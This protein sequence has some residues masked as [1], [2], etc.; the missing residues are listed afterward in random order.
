MTKTKKVKKSQYTYVKVKKPKWWATPLIFLMMI[1]VGINV[2]VAYLAFFAP[3]KLI[4]LTL[5]IDDLVEQETGNTI[6]PI[7]EVNYFSNEDGSGVEAFELRFNYFVAFDQ[8][9][10]YSSGV[11]MINPQYFASTYKLQLFQ[12]KVHVKLNLVDACYYNTDGVGTEGET[13]FSVSDPM[14]DITSNDFGFLI[15]V[16]DER[17][18]LKFKGEQE[19]DGLTVQNQVI[20]MVGYPYYDI[21]YFTAQLCDTVKTM[22]KDEEGRVTFAMQNY[23]DFY[24]DNGNGVFTKIDTDSPDWLNI[25]EA[26]I[27]QYLTIQYTTHANGLTESSESLFKIVQNDPNWS[28]YGATGTNYEFGKQI[29]NLTQNDLIYTQ[30]GTSGTYRYGLSES[31]INEYSGQNVLFKIEIDSSILADHGIT[32]FTHDAT[33]TLANTY[34]ILINNLEVSI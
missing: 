25:I 30:I 27:S 22:P 26:Q 3:S 2:F 18:Q 23:F 33:I 4:K 34:K 21:N 5:Q 10:V 6:A 28:L 31:L 9:T 17:I 19:I 20:T 29:I 14:T 24:K 16:G 7:C 12:G 32:I 11:Q 1:C 8:N 15:S 13:S